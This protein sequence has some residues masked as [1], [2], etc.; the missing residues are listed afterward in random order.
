MAEKNLSVRVLHVTKTT[1]EWASVTDNIARGLLCVELTEDGRTLLKVGTG[2]ATYANL[3][4]VQDA[5]VTIGNYYTKT[6]TDTQIS[7]AVAAMGNVVTVKGV[8]ASVDELPTADNKAGDIWFVGTDGDTTDN[9]TEYVWTTAGKWE[10]LGKVQTQVD[11]S[12]YYTKTEVDATVKTIND[13]IDALTERMGTAEGKIE[14]LEE[15]SHTHAN[16]AALDKLTE[17]HITKLEGLENYDDTALA[18]RV[19]AIEDDYLTSQDTLVMQ[20]TL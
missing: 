4:Y 19:K 2:S 18:A 9:F 1:A 14:T 7:D 13:K 11:L 3:K 8:K 6:E 10:Y 16:T 12:G 5:S 15:A 17:D 20:C